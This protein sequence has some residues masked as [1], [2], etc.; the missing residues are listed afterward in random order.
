MSERS[1]KSR[2]ERGA[3]LTAKGW[4]KLQQAIQAVEA[5]QNWGQR[6]TR[7]Q[8]ADRTGLSLQTITRILKRKQAVDR[9]SIEY[10]LRGFELQLAQGDCAP[11]SYPFEQLAARQE[12]PRQDWGEAID[13]SVFYGREQDLARL[14]QWLADDCCRLVAIV[15]IGGIGK[16]ALAVKLG[17]QLQPEFEIAIWRSLANAP[18]LADFLE[19]VLQFLLWA[20]REDPL[21]PASLDGRLTKLMTCLQR[22]RCLLIVDNVETILS[23]GSQ[24]GQYREGYEGYGQLLRSLGEVP[25]Q[26]CVLLTSREKPKEIALLE[27]EQLP[28]RSCQLAGLDVNEGRELFQSKG[29][30]VGTDAEWLKLIEHYRG[31]PLALKM[32]AALVRD[33]LEG[34]IAAVLDYIDRGMAVFE[35]IR[36]L[37]ARQVERLA[38]AE[39]EV[40]LWL[41]INREPT[42]LAALERDLVTLAT[43]RSL[44]DAIQSLLR[45]SIVEQSAAGF[46]LQPVVMAY[47]TELAIER[48]CAE[49]CSPQ[50]SAAESAPLSPIAPDFLLQTHAIVKAQ[51]KDFIRETQ[52][53]SIVQPILERL[54]TTLGGRQSIERRFQELL[55]Q[56][57]RSPQPG[58]LGG[59]LLNLLVYLNTDLQNWDFSSLNVWQAD[60]RQTSLHRVNFQHANLSKSMFAESLSGILSIDLS[61]DGTLLATGD[62]DNTIQIWRLADRQP[63]LALQGHTGWIWSVRFSPD[64]RTLASGS[65]DACVRLWDVQTGQCLQVLQGHT[66]WIWSVSFSPDG[67]ML[68][69]GSNDASLRLWDLQTGQCQTLL[70]DAAGAVGAVCFSPNGRILASGSCDGSVRLWHLSDRLC[71]TTLQGH[72]QR[73]RSVSF[74]ADGLLLASGS[75]DGLVKLW[76]VQT[77]QCLQTLHGHTSGVWTVAFSPAIDRPILGVGQ[78]LASGADDFTVRLWDV[79][80]GQCLRTLQGHTSW[81]HSVRFSPDGQLLASGSIDFSVRLWD[82]QSGQCLNVLQG[83]KSGVWAIDFALIDLTDPLGEPNCASEQFPD[84]SPAKLILASGGLD[85]VLR[86]WDVDRGVCLRTLSG[87]T[88][89]VRSVS[90]N[91]QKTL[92]ASAG[93]DRTIRLWNVRSGQCLQVLQGHTSGIRA[94]SF[95]ADGGQL[96]S[97]G[98]DFVVRVWD[99]PT[100]RCS[101]VLE[102]HTSWVYSVRFSPS[103]QTIASSG[104]DRTVRLWD[105]ATGRCLHVLSGHT[106]AVWSIDFSPDGQTLASSGFDATVR[107]WDVKTGRCVQMIRGGVNRIRSVKFSPNGETIATCGDDCNLRLWDVQS[108]ECVRVFP[109]HTSEV[110]VVGFSP[111]GEM[112]A[113]GSQDETI[114]LWD[115]QTGRCLNTLRPDRLYE[116]MNIAG[117][118]GLTE[119][120]KMALRTLGAIFSW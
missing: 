31:N 113:S 86:L 27:G 10:F 83:H 114:K 104:E 101:Q 42:S 32:V 7:E 81:V 30:F 96:A 39:R 74:S 111:D 106:S 1:S 88:S 4:Q 20:Q 38:P 108:G 57:R 69:S 47:V 48:V 43:G 2:R 22:Q 41:A 75:E 63:L 25:H 53:R 14:Q 50:Q 35:D 52:I 70:A 33:F 19:S 102:G 51:S 119:V 77:Q 49:I 8:I 95:S 105:G 28:V 109:G 78:M 98:F 103:G 89:W 93:F 58:Y 56:Q 97:G 65:N 45:R 23:S 94:V 36:D 60:L 85:A 16:S 12:D 66:D 91:P 62:V 117:A 71:L 92:L 29:A 44:P 37:L 15:G 115:V 40:L 87:H 6:L 34:R 61:P 72:F 80:S 79:G 64:G 21:V 5:A 90:F 76:D 118:I 112:L 55:Q 54:L 116:G 26:S 107:L 73:V 46:T 99:V 100:G 17:L 9:L 59:N 3:I 11:P 13:V 82:V 84:R 18:P 67:R 120:Q 68:A 24:A 110:W